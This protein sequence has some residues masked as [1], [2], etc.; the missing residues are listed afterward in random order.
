MYSRDVIVKD[1]VGL[2]ARSLNFFYEDAC[3]YESS[4]WVGK[5]NKDSR[6]NAKSM[7]G[8]LSLN[9]MGGEKI[10]IIADGPDEKDAVDHLAN[11]IET[12]FEDYK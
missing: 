8:V 2:H 3:M 9:I 10:K 5:E 11:M 7:I 1:T 6:V 4:I 12:G